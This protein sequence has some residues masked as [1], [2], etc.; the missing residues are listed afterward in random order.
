MRCVMMLCMVVISAACAD[1]TG[2]MDHADA[3]LHAGNYKEAAAGYEAALSIAEKFDSNDPRIPA[4]WNKLGMTYDA[5]GRSS[6]AVR[7]YGRALTWVERTRG[8]INSDYGTLLNNLAGVYLEQ[9][10]C[11]QAEPLIRQAVAIDTAVLPADDLR[12]AMA[13]SGLADMEIKHRR[14][15]ESEQLLDQAIRV[16]EERPGVGRDLGIARNNLA[17][18]RRYQKR[19]EESRR[20]LESALVAIETDSGPDHPVLARVLNNLG[21]AYAA[22]ARPQEA[23]QSFRRSIAIAGDRLGTEHPLYGVMLYNYARFLRDSGRKAE[24]KTL[25]AQS[26]AVI[27]ESEQRNAAGMTVDVSAF[28]RK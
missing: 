24:A 23:E 19:H 10:R 14:Y 6:D 26:R 11:D 28:R 18:V 9:G 12:L 2:L 20:L 8:K 13:R 17:V 25:E 1:W 22:L 5:L 21:I 15:R 7:M 4:T 27:R 3:Q 16:F